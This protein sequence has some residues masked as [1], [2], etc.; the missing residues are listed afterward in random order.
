MTARLWV[1]ALC[2]AGFTGGSRYVMRPEDIPLRQPLAGLSQHLGA[3][4]G[5]DGPPFS[6]QVLAVLGADDYVD[7][8]YRTSAGSVLSL[9]VGYYKSQRSGDTIHSPMNC[10]PGAGWQPMQT[11]Y[12]TIAVPGA[13]AP[14]TVKRVLI[15][16]GL[17]R[18]VVLYWYQS[19]GRIVANEYWSK[20]LM[21]YDAIRLN[22]SDAALVRIISPV[23]QD[24]AA[25][26]RLAV[27]FVQ[28]AVPQLD[29]Y[30]PA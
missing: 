22:R 4:T 11:G 29:A 23:G 2:F 28:T 12:M 6:S 19:H 3:W 10:L 25:A 27:D 30:L 16:K 8:V 17:D 1:I 15:Q 20:I 21:V 13:A 26:E 24:E 5:Q 9:Y 14:M 7:R 18:Q